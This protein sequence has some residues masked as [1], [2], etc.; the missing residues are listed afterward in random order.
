MVASL[1][2]KMCGYPKFSFGI[3]TALATV[4]SASPT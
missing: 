2:P 3:P 1:P 4:G